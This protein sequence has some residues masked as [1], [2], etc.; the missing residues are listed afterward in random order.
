MVVADL[1]GDHRSGWPDSLQQRAGQRPRTG[2]GLEHPGAREHVAPHEDL[3]G[4]LR[5]DDL[6]AARHRQHVVGQQRAQREVGR[7]DRG[8]DDA[9]LGLA[10]QVVVGQPA[11]VGVV[12]PACLQGQGVAAALGV[13]ELDAVAGAEGATAGGQLRVVARQ[14][15]RQ[16]HRRARSAGA[17]A[18]GGPS[19]SDTAPTL[20]SPPAR[21]CLRLHAN[22]A[23]ARARHRSAPPAPRR[24]S[25]G[26]RQ[27]ATVIAVEACR[28][29]VITVCVRARSVGH[30]VGGS[31]VSTPERRSPAVFAPD[32]RS[33]ERTER[34]GGRAWMR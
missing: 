15:H 16:E 5:V 21:H 28:L 30:A 9:A 23:G 6:R 29:L 8:H 33:N 3:R 25:T 32:R 26:R 13:G 12:L 19:R 17:P 24:T 11:A 22:A 14:A 20:A 2:A 7:A 34:A 27:H 10:D 4:V 18:R 31:T 1:V